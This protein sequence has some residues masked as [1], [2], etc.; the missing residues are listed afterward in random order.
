M[1]DEA[2]LDTF[3]QQF[4]ADLGAALHATT[5]VIGDK[6]GLYRALAEGGPSTAGDLAAATGCDRRLVQ[7]WLDAQCASGYC[8]FSR[9]T[10][11]YWLS[12]E[13]AAVLADPGSP[14]FLIGGMAVA[15]AVARDEDGVRR[16]FTEGGGFDW[17]DRH[18]DLFHGIERLGRPDYAAHLVPT[19]VPKLEGVVEALEAGGSVADV[20]CGHGAAAILL[21]HAYPSANIHGF[22]VHRAS[23][24][25]ARKRAVEAGGPPVR[26]EV[27]AAHDFPG[28]DYELICVFDALHD[29]GDP[30]GAARHIREALAPDG[31]WL[32]VEPMA[33]EGADGEAWPNGRALASASMAICT[34]VAQAQPG[35]WALGNQVP[36]ATWS[37]VAA[38]AG[39]SRFRRVAQTTF[40][41]VFE[42]R[43]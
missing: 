7:A 14:V 23:I 22:D 19:W 6:L 3:V 33:R 26:F 11:A 32:L 27:A 39:F 21:A 8:R 24:D 40:H 20:G 36:D 5:V 17:Q 41:R 16:A 13:Q 43:P 35:G 18:H 4:M 15:T 42:A 10:S 2:R 28:A 38:D 12:P 37:R 25:I 34:P 9:Q 30:I 1:I 31:T 29:M